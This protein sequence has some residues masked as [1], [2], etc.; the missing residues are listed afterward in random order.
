MRIN[1]RLEREF[2]YRLLVDPSG[3]PELDWLPIK[4]ALYSVWVCAKRYSR[5]NVS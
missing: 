4:K 2:K 1:H 3:Q 5:V